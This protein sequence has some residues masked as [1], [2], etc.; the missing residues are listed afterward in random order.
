[1]RRRSFLAGAAGAAGA[2]FAQQSAIP[3][4]DTHIHLFDTARPG[5]VPWPPKDNQ[6]LYMPALPP[7]YRKLAEPF[8]IVGAIEVEASPIIEDNQWVLDIAKN[9]PIIVGTVGHLEPADLDFRRNFDR[10]HKNPLFLGIRYGNL[11]GRDLADELGK[12]EFVAGLKRVAD[13]GLV[14]DTAN[15]NPKLMETMVKVT[16]RVPNLR[17]VLDHLPQM[18]PAPA[19]ATLRELAKRPQVYVKVS[20]VL[21][22]V[23]G[24]VP[25]DPAFYRA[26]LDELFGLFG[27]DRLVYGS[28]WPNSDNWAPYPAVF[29]VVREYFTAKGRAVAEKY[30]WKNSKKAYR[31]VK[32]SP[33]QPA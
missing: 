11:W 8:G 22:R 31:W 20:S 6:A 17:V 14:L 16:D 7:R 4:I 2:A 32:R 28:D 24:R 1:M 18:D 15:P 33:G 23:D 3:V 13:A 12:P 27:E 5:G 25:E 26:R 29:H 30:F 10:F 21:R 19:M 9:D